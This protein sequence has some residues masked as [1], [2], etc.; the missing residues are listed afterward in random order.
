MNH[1]LREIGPSVMVL[2]AAGTKKNKRKVTPLFPDITTYWSRHTWATLA[3]K[4]GIQLD[5]ISLAL[6][7]SFGSKTTR[8]YVEFE[9]EKIDVANR[10]VI[11]ELCSTSSEEEAVY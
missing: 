3:H 11:D 2:N 5:D 8:G 9:Q 1:Y 4:H 7:H 6:G 10:K